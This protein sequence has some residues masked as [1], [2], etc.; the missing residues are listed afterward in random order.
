MP[1]CIRRIVVSGRQPYAQVSCVPKNTAGEFVQAQISGRCL[2]ADHVRLS[3]IWLWP[4][5][6]TF[7][8]LDFIHQG[9]CTVRNVR[10]GGFRFMLSHVSA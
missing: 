7:I 1:A 8:L 3:R 10:V 9:M 2:H 4:I 5:Y 6:R